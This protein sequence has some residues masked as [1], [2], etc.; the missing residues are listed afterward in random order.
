MLIAGGE[1]QG[2]NNGHAGDLFEHIGL[3]FQKVAWSS[4]GAASRNI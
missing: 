1:P 3:F 4:C 2:T